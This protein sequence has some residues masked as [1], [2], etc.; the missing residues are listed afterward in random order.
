VIIKSTTKKFLFPSEEGFLLLCEGNRK[1][2]Q[3]NEEY[4]HTYTTNCKLD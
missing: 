1:I 2:T 3:A 4:P